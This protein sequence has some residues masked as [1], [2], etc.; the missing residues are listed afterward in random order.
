MLFYGPIKK[1]QKEHIYRL[2]KKKKKK[3]LTTLI[4]I[5]ILSYIFGNHFIK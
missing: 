2:T 5:F 4:H 1:D 3:N